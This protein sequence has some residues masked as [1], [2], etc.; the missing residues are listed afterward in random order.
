MER[1]LFIG[2]KIELL[3]E[4]LGNEPGAIGVVYEE[5]DLGEGCGVS[6]I[7]PNGDYDGFSFQEQGV[8][9]C[10]I[11]HEESLSNYHF[12]NVLQLSRD[13]FKGYFDAALKVNR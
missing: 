9:F 11:G 5:Y 2:D 3:R 8:F 4:C 12:T 10:K 7:F 6:I 13:F 1:K